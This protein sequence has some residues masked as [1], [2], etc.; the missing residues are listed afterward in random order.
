MIFNVSNILDILG[1]SRYN[2]FG[3]GKLPKANRCVVYDLT[4]GASGVAYS[5]GWLK[6]FR[7]TKVW[8]AD[9]IPDSVNS[10]AA[11][12][13]LPQDQ[14]LTRIIALPASDNETIA[15]LLKHTVRAELPFPETVE[16]QFAWS[17]IAST[18]KQST[19][20]LAAARHDAVDKAVLDSGNPDCRV[21]P[22]FAPLFNLFVTR[23]S[24]KRDRVYALLH[25]T[26]RTSFIVLCRNRELLGVQNLS[27]LA[28]RGDCEVAMTDDEALVLCSRLAPLLHRTM[29]SL[30]TE[31]KLPH[32]D[33]VV[34]S[35][36]CP[37]PAALLTGLS[38]KLAMPVASWPDCGVPA[39]HLL[40]LG[41]AEMAAAPDREDTHVFEFSRPEQP[42]SIKAFTPLT[43]LRFAC[44]GII[45]VL[46]FLSLQMVLRER[47]ESAYAR[48]DALT[49]ELVMLQPAVAAG[50]TL[51]SENREMLRQLGQDRRSLL[52]DYATVVERLSAMTPADVA[53]EQVTIGG[54][55][56]LAVASTTPAGPS[57]G[58]PRRIGMA[59]GDSASL[60]TPQ[61]SITGA[62]RD[63]LAFARY[64]QQLEQTRLLANVT[65]RHAEVGADGR[66]AF[67]LAGTL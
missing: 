62:A 12:V 21:T 17:V 57:A 49:N 58:T 39:G 46:L 27:G 28:M 31:Q 64:C 7:I 44:H 67:A 10:P 47:I 38:E 35:G 29:H 14:V 36:V 1:I 53:L 16:L 37:L 11:W 23:Y 48:A 55:A 60:N 32:I 63:A 50:T 3:S 66:F 18:E 26:P 52:P 20:L 61:V 51:Y 4:N 56:N 24:A 22:A 19:I 6:P 30:E 33:E 2:Y 9:A 8:Y 13:T 59:T 25:L 65:C 41:L 5:V 34:V 54:E 42:A 40:A 15:G 43:A 45:V